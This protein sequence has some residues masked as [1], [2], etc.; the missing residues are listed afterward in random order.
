MAHETLYG[1]TYALL[2]H[3]L[4]KFGV[5]SVLTDP[6]RTRKSSKNSLTPKTKVVYL[7]PP[8]TP[9]MEILDIAAISQVV[10]SYNPAIRVIV[11]NTFCSP[12]LQRPLEL[13]ADVVVHSA[14]KYLNGHGDVIAGLL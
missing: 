10:H 1:C 14:T 2:S 12:Y 8:A 13:G 3:G 6:V 5:T 4:T 9:T 7:R 11:D